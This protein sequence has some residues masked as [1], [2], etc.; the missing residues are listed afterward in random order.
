M[1]KSKLWKLNKFS[2]IINLKITKLSIGVQPL[3]TKERVQQFSLVLKWCW[4]EISNR[5]IYSSNSTN[6]CPRSLHSE[7]QTWANASTNAPCQTAL[8]ASTTHH[9]WA[10]RT[11]NS[12]TL[13]STSSIRRWKMGI[14]T[15]SYHIG[16]SR[17]WGRMM[18][19]TN[20]G[21]V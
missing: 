19:W 9:N 18:A 10:G 3:K 2:M 11:I 12:S 17:S 13:N 8:M 7:M 20:R 15:G 6:S 14:W 4:S 16:S 5:K 1:S 21:T